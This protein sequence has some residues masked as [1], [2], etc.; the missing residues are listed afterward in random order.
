MISHFP[1]KISC[2]KLRQDTLSKLKTLKIDH[3]RDIRLDQ[4][5]SHCH[6][7]Q[8]RRLSQQVITVK[9]GFGRLLYKSEK[10]S[11]IDL[12]GFVIIFGGILQITIRNS[13]LSHIYRFRIP[14]NLRMCFHYAFGYS[15]FF[16]RTMCVRKR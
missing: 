10:R 6:C 14:R 8:C 11:W 3:P 12:S 13:P 2:Q 1:A 9:N 4:T 7:P 15:V 5:F 16:C